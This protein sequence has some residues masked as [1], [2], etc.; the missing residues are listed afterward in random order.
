MQM[1]VSPLELAMAAA[2]AGH[3]EETLRYLEQS[4]RD[5]VPWLVFI[6]SEPDLDFVRS[7]PRYQA[8]V[9]KMGLP[10]SS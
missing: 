5:H 9:K 2:R 4:C 10:P 1:Y 8:I 7:E 3:K 6:G